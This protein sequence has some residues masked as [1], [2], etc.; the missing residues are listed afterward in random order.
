MHTKSFI[1][2]KTKLSMYIALVISVFFIITIFYDYYDNSQKE[3]IKLE[4]DLE[5]IANYSQIAL[6]DPL[7]NLDDVGIKNVMDAMFTNADI[8]YIRVTGIFEAQD[9]LK[10]IEE[11]KFTEDLM[12]YIERDIIKK[13]EVI[14]HIKI[15][16]SIF[17]TQQQLISEIWWSIVKFLILEFLMMLTIGFI[18]KKITNPIMLLRLRTKEIAAGDLTTEIKIKTNDEVGVLAASINKMQLELK[19]NFEII[20]EKN[21]R[22]LTFN[23]LLEDTV[24]E[25]TDNLRSTI[26][27]LED[28]QELLAESK[29]LASMGQLVSGLS[30]EM[31]TPLGV[32]VTGTSY[33][34]KINDDLRISYNNGELKKTELVSLMENINASGELISSS[35]VRVTELISQFKKMSGNIYNEKMRKFSLKNILDVIALTFQPDNINKSISISID[36]QKADKIYSNMDAFNEIFTH[37]MSNSF[38]HAFRNKESGKINVLSYIE[39]DILHLLYNDD[40]DGISKDKINQIFDPFYTT[41]RNYGGIGLGLSIISNIISSFGG[42]ITCTSKLNIGTNFH[43]T[44]PINIEG[45]VLSTTNK[46]YKRTSESQF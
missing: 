23:Q 18:S 16:I 2:I 33:I 45:D 4:G 36:T 9:F 7:W 6:T 41:S 44:L 25:R 10:Q 11:D 30:H 14:G 22:I 32:C 27:E 34:M 29:K 31:N 43:I 8:G 20:H 5:L 35:L 12:K 42:N 24:K 37:L 39:D 46:P 26:L 17:T 13:E 40:G 15:G 1:S 21:N 28:M 3:L 19:N 38:A